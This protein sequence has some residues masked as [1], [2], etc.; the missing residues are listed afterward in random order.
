MRRKACSRNQIARV[1]I[2][3]LLL[4]LSLSAS[5]TAR[6]PRQLNARSQPGVSGPISLFSRDCSEPYGQ[7]E[8]EFWRD[9]DGELCMFRYIFDPLAELDV[10]N[11]YGM[12]WA[13]ISV[14]HD[15]FCI[16]AVEPMLLFLRL[17]PGFELRVVST[18][19]RDRLVA[20]A[21]RTVRETLESDAGGW[22]TDDAAHLT[23]TY[24]L[25]PRVLSGGEVKVFDDQGNQRARWKWSGHT[26]KRLAFV[27]GAVVSWKVGQDQVFDS[28]D[29]HPLD[30]ATGIFDLDIGPC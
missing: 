15:S 2:A 24:R 28:L 22:A 19:P 12:V 17:L 11:D 23:Q 27:V 13:Q 1:L 6:P 29:F 14:D 21:A 10:A 18:T 20:R 7:Y 9:F 16:D 3:S 8:D 25:L 26:S 30:S 5:A 4:L